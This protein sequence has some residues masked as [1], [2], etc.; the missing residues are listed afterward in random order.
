L[1][2]LHSSDDHI[3]RVHEFEA[4]SDEHAIRISEGWR[5]GHHTELW[6]G[7]R[8]VRDWTAD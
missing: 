3:S 2:F 4:A 6:S 5:E 7:N 1:Y 8:K